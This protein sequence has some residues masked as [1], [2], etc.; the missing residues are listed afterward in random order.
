MIVCF[1][2]DEIKKG[3]IDFDSQPWPCVSVGAK[4]LIKRMLNKN[5]KERISAEN[6]LGKPLCLRF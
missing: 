6:V 3:I 1:V 4:D 5:Q 2:D